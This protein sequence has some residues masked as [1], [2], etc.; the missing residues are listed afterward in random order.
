MSIIKHFVSNQNIPDFIKSDYSLFSSFV[1]AYYEWLETQNT[2]TN[3]SYSDLYAAVGNPA[4][5]AENPEIINDIDSTLDE[6]IDFF[7]NT[8]IP[9]SI[10]ALQTD[11]RFLLKKARELYLA[12]G[13]TKSFKLFFKLFYS[14]DIEVFET[15]DAVLRA[16][17]GKYFSFPTAYVA[18]TDFEER[19]G[20]FDFIFAEIQTP[21]GE[22][23]GSIL[24]AE[25]VDKNENNKSI[26]RIKLATDVTLE[27]ETEYYLVDNTGIKIE[28]T[29]MVTITDVIIDSSGPLYSVNDQILFESNSLSKN[30]Y[31]SVDEVSSGSVE[32]IIVRDRGQNYITQDRFTFTDGFYESGIL[33]P[34]E[35]GPSGD[36]L[37]LNGIP[38]RTGTNNTGFLATPTNEVEIPVLVNRQ[39]KT[40][41]NIL[42]RKGSESRYISRPYGSYDKG[43]AFTGVPYS[44]SIGKVQQIIVSKSNYF[45]NDSDISII[46]PKSILIENSNLIA[47]DKVQFLIFDETGGLAKLPSDSESLTLTFN[48]PVITDYDSD[49]E[50]FIRQRTDSITVPYGW[51]SDNMRWL[52]KNVEITAANYKA[53]FEDFINH[54]DST[55]FGA[56]INEYTAT[57]GLDG[58]DDFTVESFDSDIDFGNTFSDSGIDGT[59]DC[60]SWFGFTDQIDYNLVVTFDKTYFGDS[61]ATINALTAL[62]NAV[63]FDSDTRYGVDL[64]PVSSIS[65]DGYNATFTISE[66]YNNGAVEYFTNTYKVPSS[67]N[68]VTGW[69]TTEIEITNRLASENVDV[70]TPFVELFDSESNISH[71]YSIS[72]DSDLTYDDDGLPVRTVTNTFEVT[73]YGQFLSSLDKSHYDSL[74]Q[75]P[76][77]DSDV[78][79][80]SYNVAYEEPN[81]I[82][83][84]SSIPESKWNTINYYAEITSINDNGIV[85]K[86]T[87]YKDYPVLTSDILKTLNEYSIVVAQKINEDDE[88]EIITGFPVSNI[89]HQI[90]DLQIT[91]NTDVVESSN[92]SFWSEAGFLSSSWG[93]V[94]QDSY[95]FSDW[96]YRIK[97]IVPFAEWKNK[98]KT[99]LHP[100]GTIATANMVS[101]REYQLST[102]AGYDRAISV[103]TKAPVITF[104][105]LQEYAEQTIDANN[106]L[107]DNTYIRSN[108]VSTYSQ[109][110]LRI[111]ASSAYGISNRK[112]KEQHG[113]GFWDFE[114][115]GLTKTYTLPDTSTSTYLNYDWDTDHTSS[116]TSQLEESGYVS[117]T[118]VKYDRS[119]SDLQHLYRND[120]RLPNSID[121]PTLNIIS[122]ENQSF[123]RY[124]ILDSDYGITYCR[125]SSDSEVPFASIDYTLLGADSDNEIYSYSSNRTSEIYKLKNNDLKLAC[126]EDASLSFIDNGITYYD[127]EAYE[128]KWN[129]INTSR[130]V[131]TEGYLIRG[132]D[133]HVQNTLVAD[134]NAHRTLDFDTLHDVKYTDKNSPHALRAY[135][136]AKL[137]SYVTWKNTYSDGTVIVENI[138]QDTYTDNKDP[139]SLMENRRGR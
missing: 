61:D 48:I 34:T 130:T 136:T 17:D 14:E 137:N 9:V 13:T 134:R 119:Y 30:F 77:I 1:E 85:G 73:M 138:T 82:T 94:I 109:D 117:N 39:W 107:S 55:S 74:A 128:R 27:K 24:G 40:L 116:L 113:N 42:Y 6:F 2:G 111:N 86:F 106:I 15:G 79:T 114:P 50:A 129:K 36:I 124:S 101:N 115:V 126:K 135:E 104:D 52:T 25:I 80:F 8:I 76:G 103:T 131:N 38:L 112:A 66:T 3:S 98:F 125:F 123:E 68:A 91:V 41:P 84:V 59:V 132:I 44:E 63:D 95:Y 75:I 72:F 35:L 89:V 122:F 43:F 65:I 121:Y 105:M 120:R 139:K 12:K 97:S 10:E 51:D 19:V 54:M 69:Q 45:K 58:G 32:K 20:Q 78:N 90:N 118:R 67:W 64:H 7:S 81:W 102:S 88:P 16:S 21:A 62:P 4:F 110:A 96:T 133:M 47:G 93:G 11:P 70:L 28:V 23:V 83:N 22:T 108:T 29:T 56:T 5:I 26:L 100:A 99:L 33:K 87:Q 71:S 31:G 18:I 37:K 127:Y 49:G 57:Y 60:G 92:K 53:M 46:T